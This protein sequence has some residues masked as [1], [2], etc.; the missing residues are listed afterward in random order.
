[1]KSEAFYNEMEAKIPKG[2]FRT[3][4][5]PS[6]TGYMHI[7]SLRTALY[8]Y[9]MA[10]KEQG[11]FILRIEDTDLERYV[12]GADEKIYSTL[13]ACNIKYDEGPDIG[14]PVGPYVQSERRELYLDYAELLIS[15]GGAYRCFCGKNA[16]GEGDAQKSDGIPAKYDGRCSRL[17]AEDIAAKIAA[18]APSIVRQK[19]PSSGSTVFV[20]KVFGRIEVEHTILDDGVLIKGDGMP[21]YNFANVV[22][23]HLMGITHIIRGSEFLSSTPKFNLLYE[24]FGWDVPQYIHCA[25]VMKDTSQKLSKR[26][27]DASFEELVEKGYLRDAL[28]NYVA[29]LGWSPG[30]EREVFSLEE[31]I[32]SFDVKGLSKSPAI[33]DYVKLNWLNGEYLRAMDDTA[34]HGLALPHI[35]GAVKREI[36]THY[37]AGL[38]KDRCDLLEDIPAQIDFFE[39]VGDYALDLYTNTKMKTSPE[40]AGETLCN[41]AGALDTVTDWSKDNIHNAITKVVQDMG[42]K[43]GQVL[44][45]LRVALSGKTSTPGSGVELCLILGKTETL[46]RIHRAVTKLR[47]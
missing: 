11:I 25:P 16:P 41:V 9:L 46:A 27:G 44:W 39:K 14:G 47:D 23:D 42:V 33:F 22:D 3:R 35:K 32:Q 18:G 31:L 15:K 38:L 34:Y 8:G 26:H 17:S 36:D 30:G 37:L 29:L 24:G 5:A 10:K 1:M 12:A 28:L 7:G 4:F 19:I 6:P 40:T 20:D 2:Q 45:P 21:T 13:A 43:N